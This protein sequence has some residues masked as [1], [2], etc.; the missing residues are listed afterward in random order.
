MNVVPIANEDR[1]LA[2]ASAAAAL[3]YARIAGA[4]LL[5][6]LVAGGF[7]ELFV[8]STLTVSADATATAHKIMASPSLF[9][10]G[11][12]GYLVEALCDVSLTLVLYVLLRPVDRNIALLAAFFGLMGTATFAIAEFFYFAA[13]LILGGAAYLKTFSPDQLNTLALLSLNLF[14]HGGEIFMAFGGV[15][16]IVL[17]YLI[18]QSGYLPRTLGTLMA[19]GGL[20]FVAS[21]FVVVTAPG[22]ATP[23]LLLPETIAMLFLGLWLLVRGV[24]V[25]K[26]EE[27]VAAVRND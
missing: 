16:S 6:S 26:W 9:R 19:L 24:D 23:F 15:G 12:A 17:G 2:Q 11:F 10:L 18:F 3:R 5:I 1:R 20:G 21:N 7:G 14:G 4:L 27:R 13:S 25:R 8:P 22:Y